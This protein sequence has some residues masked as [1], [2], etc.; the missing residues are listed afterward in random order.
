MQITNN[1]TKAIRA[2]S[3]DVWNAFMV[4]GAAFTEN[5]IPVC[6]TV[7]TA[8]PTRII[9][10]SEAKNIHKKYSKT[11]RNYFYDAFIC[12]YIDDQDFDGPRSSIWT[13]YWK[14][15]R[16]IR[17]F[18]GIIT[19]DFSTFMDFPEPLCEYNTYRMRAFGY[20]IGK[21]GIE[22][23]NN[24]RWGLPYTYRYCFDGI[25]KNSVVAIGTVG[26][27]PRKLE[28]RDRFERG[29]FETIE[30]LQPHTIIVYG[31]ANYPCFDIL[32]EKGITIIAYKSH[33]CAAYER[34]VKL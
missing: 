29:L 27:S 34:S 15:I 9:T 24:V 26:G 6:P 7:I 28:D 23:V 3:K 1:K 13:F 18:K 8:P 21:T 22:V 32:R 25:E 11:D 5:D 19:P 31:S 10:W 14:A 20:W 30:R 2:G 16:I 12:F 17:H 4:D 33:T